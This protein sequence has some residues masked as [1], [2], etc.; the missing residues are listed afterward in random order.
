[1]LMTTLQMTFHGI[2]IKTR[3]RIILLKEAHMKYRDRIHSEN[4]EFK[5]S[6]NPLSIMV[7]IKRKTDLIKHLRDI[8]LFPVKYFS[9]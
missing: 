9:L 3:N 1:M 2:K 7:V 6:E 8:L 4:S 5:S